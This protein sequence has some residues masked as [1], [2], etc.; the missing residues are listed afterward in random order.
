[1]A[2][3]ILKKKSFWA[4]LPIKSK[5][6]VF[7]LLLLLVGAAAAYALSQ[8]SL[9]LQS[10]ASLSCDTNCKQSCQRITDDTQKSTCLNVCLNRCTPT[11]SVSAVCRP[12][13]K[14]ISLIESKGG[15]TKNQLNQ[16][17]KIAKRLG[18]SI[19][20]FNKTDDFVVW[21]KNRCASSTC[22]PDWTKV[23]SREAG[24]DRMPTAREV[25]NIYYWPNG[26]KGMAENGRMCTQA[27]VNL[28]PEEVTA[29]L[30]WLKAGK[31]SIKN[32]CPSSGTTVPDGCRY[33]QVRCIQAPC[34]PVLV[35]PSPSPGI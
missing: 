13:A 4:K 8:S 5:V 18:E 30:A 16:V 32:V 20:T 22:Q 33:E 15:L 25:T 14:Y 6:G 26:C 27:T 23:G 9:D 2:K 34:D 29:Y 19:G 12:M 3:K 7:A 24:R 10:K 1:M 17:A 35:C 21:Y 28:T 31:P 11:E